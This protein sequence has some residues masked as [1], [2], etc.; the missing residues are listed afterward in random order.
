MTQHEIKNILEIGVMLSSERDLEKL[1]AR[2]LDCVMDL[3]RCDAGTLYLLEGDHLAFKLMRNRSRQL[4]TLPPVPLDREHVCAL[5][6]LDGRTISIDDVYLS[7]ECDFSGTLRYDALTGYRT[8]SMLVVPMIGRQGEKLGV[9]QLINALD[10]GG[11]VA[12]FPADMTL[13]L[14]SA[15]SQ[16]AITILN[17]RYIEEIR[18]LFHSFVRVMSAAIGE[19]TPYNASHTM[20]MAEYCGRF[21]D[22]LNESAGY[23]RFDADRR[24]EL[25][26][27]VWLHDVGKLIT[28]LEVMNKAGRLRP[29][30]HDALFH[31][32]EVIRL[33][34]EI[35]RLNGRI[36][37]EELSALEEDTYAA[38]RF[39]DEIDA[40]DFLS[41]E[42]LARVDALA[43]RTYT[44]ADGSIRPWLTEEEHKMLSIRGG[45]LSPEERKI[46]EKHV[47]FT[48]KL[49]SQ[50]RFSRNLSHVRQWAA[51]HHELLNGQG[52]PDHL[53]GDAIPEEVRII[54]ILDVF[55]AL[56]A[57][58]RP[59]KEGKPVPAAL[60]ILKDMAAQGR[61][62]SELLEQFTASRCWE[63]EEENAQ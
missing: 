56:V 44:A 27:S 33:R 22:Y 35:D 55:D 2:V 24:E 7:R 3:A 28:P 50:I 58:D 6:F 21:L 46:M 48:D 10:D 62:D 36:T 39:I 19:L 42:R 60:A 25:L 53:R 63:T 23:E 34:G 54:T 38:Q 11:A 45:T 14:E 41:D 59:Y 43:E 15:A 26:T 8:R 5:S 37:P 17:A 61:L 57:S 18:E 40:A 51:S 16:A 1:L 13:V 12:P 32:L 30:Q 49:L 20:H 4:G 52:Y 47:V 29:E 31:R 9:I